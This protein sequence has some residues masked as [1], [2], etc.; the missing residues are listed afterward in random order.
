[1]VYILLEVTEGVGE[2]R[3]EE[4]G[5]ETVTAKKRMTILHYNASNSSIMEEEG[6]KEREEQFSLTY[7]IYII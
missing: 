7:A 3:D 1:M 2:E 6:Q 4:M 5:V